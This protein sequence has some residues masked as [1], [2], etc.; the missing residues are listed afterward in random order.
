MAMAKKSPD[1]EAFDAIE[2][3]KQA[4]ERAQE[5]IQE[6]REK[7]SS[8]IIQDSYEEAEKIKARFLTEAKEKADGIKK[9]IIDRAKKERN[10]IEKESDKEISDLR[11]KTRSRMPGAVEK[12]RKIVEESLKKGGF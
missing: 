4:E 12:I 9:E 1:K 8:Q 11:Q 6:A 2:K 5:I 3:I 7:T 10:K